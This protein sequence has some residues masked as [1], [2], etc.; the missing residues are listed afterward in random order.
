LRGALRAPAT[1]G[2][3]VG[4]GRAAGFR[5]RFGRAADRGAAFRVVRFGATF[6][7]RFK[8]SFRAVFF[9]AALRLP[10][11]PR[12]AAVLRRP[13][14]FPARAAGRDGRLTGFFERRAAGFRLA[15]MSSPGVLVDLG[16]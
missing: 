3:A 7:G 9:A 14:R 5:V 11:R 13:G 15:M 4:A 16:F 8:A 2:A 12:A 10:A 6:L 1:G